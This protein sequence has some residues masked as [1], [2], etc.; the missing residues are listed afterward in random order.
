MI[1]LEASE[2]PA[3]GDDI[4]STELNALS[5]KES[6]VSGAVNANDTGEG[7]LDTAIESYDPLRCLFCNVHSASLELNLAHMFKMHGMF[8]P[9]QEYLNDTE[10]LLGYLF[11]IISEFHTC[12]SCGIT[13]S[14]VEGIQQHMKDKG[15]CM[16]NFDDDTELELFYD[17]SISESNTEDEGGANPTHENDENDDERPT[18]PITS[19]EYE[20]H[21][22]SGKTLGHRSHARYYRQNLHNYPTPAERAEQRAIEEASSID[23]PEPGP[24]KG[25]R[26]ATRANGGSGMIGVP[27]TQKRALR[28][29][30]KK[31]LKLD[32][33]ARN[34]FQWAVEKS[35]NSQKHFHN[36]VPGPKLG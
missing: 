17:F 29:V 12:L 27:E 1:N 19:S 32:I 15:H 21:L 35:S 36:D 25:R 11:R 4:K 26:V 6:I 7:S 8:I 18:D 24:E 34:Q 23:S 9:N 13:K 30:E 2:L 20:L 16:I 22:P 3:V 28:A 33:R 14:T 5:S 31:M 10:S